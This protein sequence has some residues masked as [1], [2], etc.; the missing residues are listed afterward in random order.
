MRDYKIGLALG[1]GGALGFCHI[2][3]IQVL[4]ENNIPI[5]I[6]T[7]TSMGAIVGGVYA[8]GE[9]NMDDMMSFAL[10]MR[11]IHLT[12][13]NFNFRGLFRGRRIIKLINKL[14]KGKK[15]ED[16]KIPFC[17]VATDLI[18]GKEVHLDHGD[19]VKAIRAS[20]SVPGLFTP[21]EY[22]DMLLIDGG[23]KNNVPGDVARNM[24]ADIVIGIRPYNKYVLHKKPNT[25]LD[26][27]SNA[28]LLTIHELSEQKNEHFDV[29]VDPKL[30]EI[31]Q[32]VFKK[33]NTELAIK[34]GRE[35]MKKALPQIKE[36]ITKFEKKSVSK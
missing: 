17:A 33:K 20:M 4:E 27:L 7:G 10:K 23:T 28:F 16:Y 30:D 26:T 14:T 36:I 11:T 5:D 3:A 34:R 22:N 29:L 15:I 1:G 12:D 35:A 2:G 21:V 6:I 31:D 25:S 13:I 24:G 19:G 9:S 8:S 18:S 32:F